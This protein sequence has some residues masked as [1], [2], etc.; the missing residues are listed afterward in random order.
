MLKEAQR[1]G[2]VE[3]KLHDPSG[4]ARRPG[5][6][7][8]RALRPE[9]GAGR[10]AQPARR[11]D[12]AAGRQPGGA[13]PAGLARRDHDRRDLVGPGPPRRGLGPP[14]RSRPR[15]ERRA[16]A[17]RHV[18]HRQ[19][20]Q[21][22]GARALAGRLARRDLPAHARPRHARLGRGRPR[23]ARGTRA[24]PTPSA[25]PGRAT[26]PSSGSGAPTS[27]SSAAVIESMALDRGGDPGL[28]GPAPRRRSRR[29]LLHRQRAPGSPARS[30][31]AS[32]R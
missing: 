30:T 26:S 31:T 13:L 10:G 16:A 28:L 4:R 18:R 20:G 5:G 1:Q 6:T 11:R 2:I 32:S 8:R 7:A 27:G 22:A 24:S 25:R 17:R 21:R 3:I 23:P 12:R 15:R 19:R 9:R 29:S 14:H